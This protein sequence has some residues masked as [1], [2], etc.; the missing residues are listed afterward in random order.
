MH[1]HEAR[2]LD[3]KADVE[4]TATQ[5]NFGVEGVMEAQHYLWHG[6]Q[7]SGENNHWTELLGVSEMTGA[8]LQIDLL[9]ICWA[10]ILACAEGGGGVKLTMQIILQLSLNNKDAC[11]SRGIP[12]S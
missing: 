7:Q 1:E 2:A 10:C 9:A 12:L 11:S 4:L 3:S 6:Q 8:F 5:V